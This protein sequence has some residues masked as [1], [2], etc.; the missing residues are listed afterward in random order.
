MR[1]QHG[2]PFT[3]SFFEIA[4]SHYGPSRVAGE[5]S[6][7]CLDLVIQVDLAGQLPDPPEEM[8][9]PLDAPGVHVLAV[10]C[11]VPSGGEDET[12]I[13]CVIEHCLRGAGRVPMNAD[14]NED[15]EHA[16]ASGRRL[17]DHAPV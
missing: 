7:T 14:G 17:L 1:A 3:V 2:E 11:D 12:C 15:R 6:P 4:P 10:E 13:G 5:D 8:D 16:V 9:L